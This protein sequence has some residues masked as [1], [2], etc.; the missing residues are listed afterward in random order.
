MDVSVRRAGRFARLVRAFFACFFATGSFSFTT[1][2]PA[3]T[4]TDFSAFPAARISTVPRLLAKKESVTAPFLATGTVA[5][6]WKL[7]VG[8]GIAPAVGTTGRG[9]VGS[10]GA[11]GET[12]VV[13]ST[14]VSVVVTVNSW[15]FAVALGFGRATIAVLPSAQVQV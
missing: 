9:S 11:S 1:L 7:S 4:F 5:G 2:R 13:R 14:A 6:P 15:P 3:R 12:I 10:T 8:G